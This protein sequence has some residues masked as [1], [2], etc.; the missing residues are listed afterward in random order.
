MKKKN[1]LEHR[2]TYTLLHTTNKDIAPDK[3][4]YTDSIFCLISPQKN[5]QIEG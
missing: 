5:T 3:K 2:S 1:E 4:E